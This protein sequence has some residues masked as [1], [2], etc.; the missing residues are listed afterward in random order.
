[1]SIDCRKF[2]LPH[3]MYAMVS[4]QADLISHI[5][6]NKSCYDSIT[7]S[8]CKMDNN[9]DFTTSGPMGGGIVLNAS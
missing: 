8:Q 3:Q 4:L 7:Q 5:S 1:M 6:F 9:P 2:A